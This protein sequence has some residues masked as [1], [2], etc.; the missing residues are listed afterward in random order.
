MICSGLQY[1]NREDFAKR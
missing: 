1:A